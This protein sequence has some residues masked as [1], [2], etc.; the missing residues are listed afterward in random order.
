[1]HYL[2]PFVSMGCGCTNSDSCSSTIQSFEC[3][4]S[5]SSAG[6]LLRYTAV[7]PD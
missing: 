4:I 7:L 3:K 2:P 5:S 6:S 1:L